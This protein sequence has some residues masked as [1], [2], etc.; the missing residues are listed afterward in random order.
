MLG[1]SDIGSCKDETGCFLLKTVPKTR[2]AVYGNFVKLWWWIIVL[3][4]WEIT[5]ERNS[6]LYNLL[7]AVDY[8]QQ[9]DTGCFFVSL[10]IQTLF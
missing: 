6:V 1:Y 2:K 8:L 9:L 5:R 3:P 10:F 4:S 7:K